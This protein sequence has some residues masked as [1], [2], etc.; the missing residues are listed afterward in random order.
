MGE[1]KLP[2]SACHSRE[3]GYRFR[4]CVK[5]VMPP[6]TCVVLA[7]CT[8][9]LGWPFNLKHIYIIYIYISLSL[10]IYIYIF[11]LFHLYGPL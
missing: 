10:Y 2:N 7:E 1:C 4:G 8:K 5:V 6:R 11:F 3:L 9:K